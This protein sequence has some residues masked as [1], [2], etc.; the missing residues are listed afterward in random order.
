M[1]E[2]SRIGRGGGP[3]SVYRDQRVR[4]TDGAM[5]PFWTFDHTADLGL[6]VRAGTMEELFT[7]AAKGLTLLLVGEY[8]VVPAGWREIQVEAPGPE[9]L[10]AD[11]LSELLILTTVEELVPVKVE[12]DRLDSDSIKVQAGIIRLKDLGGLKREIKAVTYHGLSVA[13]T[14][15]GLEARLVFDV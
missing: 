7:E 15:S 11:F 12:I 14:D 8:P 9:I 5:C 1:G 4:Y 6:L 3:K 10:L 2:P 13:E